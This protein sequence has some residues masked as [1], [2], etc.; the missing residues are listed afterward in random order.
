MNDQI[1][2]KKGDEVVLGVLGS[3]WATATERSKRFEYRRAGSWEIIPSDVGNLETG[4]SLREQPSDC[5]TK[6]PGGDPGFDDASDRQ[7]MTPTGIEP[8]LPP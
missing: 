4:A 2:D 5:E 3:N 7:T 1:A 6:K 8:V